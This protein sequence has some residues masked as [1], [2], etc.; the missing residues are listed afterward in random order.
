MSVRMHDLRERATG[1]RCRVEARGLIV[2]PVRP[3]KEVIAVHD[4]ERTVKW[5]E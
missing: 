2:V 4:Q 5:V 3:E 1:S